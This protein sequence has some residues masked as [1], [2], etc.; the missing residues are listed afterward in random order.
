MR[1]EMRHV[2]AAAGFVALIAGGL[3]AVTPSTAADM[4]AVEKR[5]KLMESN[6]HYVY[7]VIPAFVRKGEGTAADVA[8]GA[9]TIVENFKTIPGLFVA[10]TST[11]DMPGK[12]HAKPDIWKEKAKFEAFEKITVA[13]AEALDA[14][15]K[16]GDKQ[17]IAA[18]YAAL[19]RDGCSAC[20]NQFRASLKR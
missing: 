14:A 10:G 15:A 12:T 16:S 4:S 17:K 8:K 5:K 13:R 9:E 3:A 11:E 7:R 2:L 20:H 18:A 6:G 19:N 1:F